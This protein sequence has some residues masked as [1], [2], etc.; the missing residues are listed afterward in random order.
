MIKHDCR[1][2]KD[3]QQ[4]SKTQ[5]PRQSSVGP[6]W[7]LRKNG[8]E[9]LKVG[10]S[11]WSLVALVRLVTL[12]TLLFLKK[13]RVSNPN[14]LQKVPLQN[15]SRNRIFFFG[16]HLLDLVDWSM[17]YWAVWVALLASAHGL[18]GVHAV[19]RLGNPD[20]GRA[21]DLGPVRLQFNWRNMARWNMVKRMVHTGFIFISL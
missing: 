17:L 19:T 20:A 15:H 1:H 5:V 6:S 4:K 21:G 14:C 9:N 16:A 10:T 11:F 12:V 8:M 3:L 2:K 13:H 18:Y 7:D